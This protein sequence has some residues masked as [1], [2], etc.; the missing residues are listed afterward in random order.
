MSD[1]QETGD[2]TRASAEPSA[3]R[4][5]GLTWLWILLAFAGGLLVP[6]LICVGLIFAVGAAASAGSSPAVSDFGFG[7]GVGVIRVEGV[8]LP[9][10]TTGVSTAAGSETIV[11][12]IEQAQASD[13]VK[14]LLLRVDSPGGGVVASDEIYHALTEFE[15][16]MV[17]SM[18][19]VAASGGYYISAP[20][21]VIFATPH[22]LT[23]SIGVISSFINAEDLLADV[24]VDVVALTTGEFKDT[25]S[26][27]RELTDEER[28]YWQAIID[29]SYDG[30][31]EIVAEGRGLSVEEVRTLADG[32]VYTGQEA[33]ELGLVDEIGYFDDAVDRAADLGGIIG[34]A[35]VI[36]LQPA[37]TFLDYLA[38]AQS[39]QSLLP[40]AL[41]LL[42]L[43][44]Q[45]SLEYR[46]VGP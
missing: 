29:Q 13:D 14:A 6:A 11:D 41:D 43:M 34:E 42:E 16:P 3:G 25:G 9:G 23:G 40:N 5:R 21:D 31:V 17:V 33:L 18:G 32:R 2:G 20:A 7:P 28:A 39:G 24:G 19:T 15:K 8:I 35:R 12:L 38:T 27:Y 26:L 36:E 22:T 4:R 44:A 10:E 37:P 30:F 45:P 1:V 46:Y